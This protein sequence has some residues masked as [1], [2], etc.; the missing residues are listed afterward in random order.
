MARILTYLPKLQPGEPLVAVS[1][2]YH[3]AEATHR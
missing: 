1:H 3:L 2:L